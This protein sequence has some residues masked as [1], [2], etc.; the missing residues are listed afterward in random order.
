MRPG[1]CWMPRSRDRAVA[2]S[3][4]RMQAARLP[5]PLFMAD[6]APSTAFRSGAYAGSCT[7]V[8]QSGWAPV[9]RRITVLRC[10]LRLSQMRMTG[11]ARARCAAVTRSS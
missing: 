1:R 7:I 6:H 11:A 2:A 9:N 8:S 10:V 5:R 4:S 3:W